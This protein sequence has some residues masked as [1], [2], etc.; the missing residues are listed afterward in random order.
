[1]AID[2]RSEIE[3]ESEI[4]AARDQ[5]LKPNTMQQNTEKGHIQNAD[6]V[7]RMMRQ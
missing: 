1:M 2:A 6:F 3:N 4:I 5:A 7:N